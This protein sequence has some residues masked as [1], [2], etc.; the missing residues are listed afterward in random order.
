MSQMLR[1][2]PAYTEA[3]LRKLYDTR[4]DHTRW[5]EHKL[6]VGVTIPVARAM[7]VGCD[8]AADLSCGDGA[9]LGAVD[10][11]RR[12][13]GDYTPGWSVVGKLE[14]TLSR[15]DR[16]GLYICSETLEHLDAPGAV[17][18]G[19]R[20][21]A[22]RL[23]LSTPVDAWDDGEQNPEHYWAWDQGAVEQ[24]LSGAG[25]CPSVFLRLDARPGGGQYCYGIWGCR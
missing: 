17:L 23:V 12:V 15:L 5:D 7:A 14:Q 21:C 1:L 16:V 25:W 10:V 2:R 4:Y 9:I 8:S 6:R 18:R 24:M 3:D 19:I 20:G 13:F 11:R 22:D